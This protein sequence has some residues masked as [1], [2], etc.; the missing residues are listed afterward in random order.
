MLQAVSLR[1]TSLIH[2]DDL[3]GRLGA[4]E[5]AVIIQHPLKEEDLLTY[6][7]QMRVGLLDSFLIEGVEYEIS[8]SFG[9]AMS[10][11]DSLDGEEL[12]SCADTAM[13]KAKEYGRNCVQF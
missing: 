12:L 13:H 6:V 4:D 11:Q 2:Q 7:E 10:P 9:V 5:F 8:A 1:L 3:L